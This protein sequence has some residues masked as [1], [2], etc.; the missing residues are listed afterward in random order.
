MCSQV[1]SNGDC[2]TMTNNLCKWGDA[3]EWCNEAA[4]GVTACI[5]LT[6]ECC[7]WIPYHIESAIK[8]AP[9]PPGDTIYH[10][11][12]IQYITIHWLH[13]ILAQDVVHTVTCYAAGHRMHAHT[14]MLTKWVKGNGPYKECSVV[15]TLPH[16]TTQFVWDRYNMCVIQTIR[17]LCTC[18][19]S[20]QHYQP[21]EQ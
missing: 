14:Y 9:P 17:L 1:V 3:I 6:S 15:K 5:L 11:L 7:A 18:M 12:V 16:W 19:R 2:C 8:Y 13:D 4:H 10:H 20:S 21:N